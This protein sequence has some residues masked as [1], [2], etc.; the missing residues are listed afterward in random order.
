[1]N[2]MLFQHPDGR[3]F[4][5]KEDAWKEVERKNEEFTRNNM[6]PLFR[7]NCIRSCICFL[8]SQPICFELHDYGR[9]QISEP[10]CTN[11]ML[12]FAP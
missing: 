9:C 2:H 1:M 5:M 11:P 8:I 10:R 4:D 7:D 6:C 12:G 3:E